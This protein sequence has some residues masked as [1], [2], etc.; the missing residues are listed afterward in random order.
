MGFDNTSSVIWLGPTTGGI[1]GT[2]LSYLRGEFVFQHIESSVA[3]DHVSGGPPLG[4]ILGL[5]VALLA[6][7][8]GCDVQR[9]SGVIDAQNIPDSVGYDAGSRADV[10]L[11]GGSGAATMAGTWVL[12]HER[13]TCVETFKTQEQVTRAVYRVRIDT[14][15]GFL[16][17]ER[18]TCDISLSPVLDQ[19]IEIEPAVYRSIEY[20][21]VDKGF[22][23]SIQPGGSYTSATEV[24]LWGLDP[25]KMDDPRT[26]PLPEEAKGEAVVDSDGDGNPAVSYLLNDGSCSR[27]NAQRQII[28][29]RGTF[30][31]PNQID[32]SSTGH[33]DIVV[34]GGSNSICAIAPTIRSND[35]D[36]R[37][38][39]YRIDGRG[40][41]VD[42]DQDGDGEIACEEIRKLP[43]DQFYEPRNPD[44]SNCEK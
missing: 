41:A 11:G 9:Q 5:S 21:D 1:A 22:V 16:D 24:A 8:A 14:D 34:Y 42:A 18:E 32:G 36:S 33:T 26:T 30:T 13:S 12:I 6:A 19:S 39:M 4:A 40:G 31:R 25:Q 29:Y 37:F 28:R 15:G 43:I 3:D 10:G 7:S 23:S 35:R 17:E 2:K 27:F 38:R 20:V 44:H